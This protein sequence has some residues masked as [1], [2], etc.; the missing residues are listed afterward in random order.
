MTVFPPF[1]DIMAL[2]SPTF[3]EKQVSPTINITMA[4]LPDLS[5]IVGFPSSSLP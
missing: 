5:T 4:Q 3:A 2:L 1:I